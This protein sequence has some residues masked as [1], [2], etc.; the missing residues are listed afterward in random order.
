LKDIP[1]AIEFSTDG[2]ELY[3]SDVSG[4]VR[5]FVFSID[6]LTQMTQPFVKDM[7][8][9][10]RGN[11]NIVYESKDPPTTTT[12]NTATIATSS[13]SSS[14]SSD[15]YPKFFKQFSFNRSNFDPNYI[16][17]G[18]YLV[19][20]LLSNPPKKAV[21][22]SLSYRPHDIEL[23]TPSI[24]IRDSNNVV[25]ILQVKRSN[26]FLKSKIK[27]MTR[28]TNSN[29]K[30]E[31]LECFTLGKVPCH[32]AGIASRRSEFIACSSDKGIL[33]IYDPYSNKRNVELDERNQ[34]F[35][36]I[37][38]HTT[39][40]QSLAWNGD[41]SILASGDEIGNVGL[42]QPSSSSA[43]TR[44]RTTKNLMSNK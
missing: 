28:S 35:S 3:V 42:W 9:S 38:A 19:D 21:I 13:S 33:Y 11:N 39:G 5:R 16:R 40:V 22:I 14:S 31:E 26:S 18:A 24:I 32:C 2:D 37:I 15:S 25:N 10:V 44:R 7:M 17:N 12:S 43:P 20:A 23:R 6:P 34:C 27:L 30:L 8:A 4:R 1:V 29:V 41:E 36:R